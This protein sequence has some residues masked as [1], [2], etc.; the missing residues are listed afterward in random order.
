MGGEAR[1]LRAV[2]FGD[3]DALRGLLVDML[4]DLRVEL[5][6]ADGG[7][8]RPD[9]VF[10][11][12]RQGD[13]FGVIELA[14]RAAFGAPIVAVM[15]LSDP[16][17]AQ[18]AALGGANAICALDGPLDDLRHALLRALERQALLRDAQPAR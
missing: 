7:G 17:V 2:V 18:R 3:S 8:A 5:E 6:F 9:L 14:R 10:A 13:V 12:V 16:K 11:V 4:R 15:A 1:R